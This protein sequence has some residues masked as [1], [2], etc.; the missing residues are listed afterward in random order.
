M[1][2]AMGFAS[3]IAREMAAAEEGNLASIAARSQETFDPAEWH[4][5]LE[6]DDYVNVRTG[7]IRTEGQFDWRTSPS[8]D[9]T[10][11]HGDEWDLPQ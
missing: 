10:L 2:G 6:S 3:K 11:F 4:Y 9:S 5:R 7:E 8:A 1:G